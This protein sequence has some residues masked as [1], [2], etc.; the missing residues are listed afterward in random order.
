MPAVRPPDGPFHQGT[1][2]AQV[3]RGPSPRQTRTAVWGS[4]HEAFIAIPFLGGTPVVVRGRAG[5][6]SPAQPLRVRPA[7]SP[8]QPLRA[9]PAPPACSSADDPIGGRAPDGWAIPRRPGPE[10]SC[11]GWSRTLCPR[12]CQRCIAPSWTGSPSWRA[13]ASAR[14]PTVSGRRPRG[15]T[16][17]DGMNKRAGISKTC[18]DA[19]PE[20]RSGRMPPLAARIGGPV[21][22]PDARDR[23]RPPATARDR[24]G[25]VG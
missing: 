9:R 4:D 13:A 18:S 19:M 25:S 22:Q 20:T 11:A 5:R 8:A 16:L 23:P 24:S 10:S 15:S 3:L 21:P 2:F 7:P 17:A 1:L 6:P 12:S 14:L